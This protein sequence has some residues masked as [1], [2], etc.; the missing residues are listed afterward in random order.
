MSSS[1][2]F[3][4]IVFSACLYALYTCLVLGKSFY[5]LLP[6][7]IITH[8]TYFIFHLVNLSWWASLHCAHEKME[9]SYIFLHLFFLLS[10]SA[11]SLEEVYIFHLLSAE[12]T[13]CF[14]LFYFI[15]FTWQRL[16]PFLSCVDIDCFSY[17]STQVKVILL[18]LILYDFKKKNL[19][20]MDVIFLGY[21]FLGYNF[22]HFLQVK[23]SYVN[24]KHI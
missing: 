12:V 5:F 15:F 6:H 14:I 20:A 11:M 10:V 9:G 3:L 24:M 21:N 1:S 7:Y 8:A 18:G 23:Y 19:E 22:L 4:S 16:C 17:F 2:L 13:L